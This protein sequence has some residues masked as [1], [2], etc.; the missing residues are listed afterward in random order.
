ME[1]YP[2][3]SALT[4]EQLASRSLFEEDPPAELFHYTDFD[5]VYGILASRCLWLSKVSTLNDT[6][7][8]KL[9]IDLF[10][11]QASEAARGLDMEEARFLEHAAGLL[12]SVRRTNICVAGFSEDK[13]QLNQWRSYA[14]DGRGIALGFDTGI[15]RGAARKHDVRLL[16]CV[17]EPEAHRRIVGDLVRLLLDAFRGTP[18]DAD[19]ARKALLDQFSS[20]FLLTAPVIKDHHFAQEK[21]WRLVSMPRSVDDPQLTAVL[22][23]N[24]ASVKL[25]L[26]LIPEGD[27]ASGVISS[28]TIGPTLD[29]DNVADA[30]DVLARHKGFRISTVRLSRVPYRP[31]T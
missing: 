29:P 5:G 30:V 14:N 28:V 21:E 12:D 7:E 2:A 17:Y 23:G 9:A 20:T 10:K 31:R 4:L 24:H 13:D 18:P 6:S 25:V 3:N 8:V 19:G 11:Q 22:Y 1:R 16:R 15:L 26:P 27:P